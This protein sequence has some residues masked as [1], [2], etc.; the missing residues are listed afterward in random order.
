MHCYADGE[1]RIFST[2]GHKRKRR[3]DCFLG[4]AW[5]RHQTALPYYLHNEQFVL[6]FS[7]TQMDIISRTYVGTVIEGVTTNSRAAS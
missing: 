3:R 2:E 7:D 1:E 4:G 5:S 6:R